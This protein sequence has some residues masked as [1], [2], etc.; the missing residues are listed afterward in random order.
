MWNIIIIILC[1]LKSNTNFII[2][3][4]PYIQ[5]RVFPQ[6]EAPYITMLGGYR[7]FQ[8]KILWIFVGKKVA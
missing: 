1:V 2:E 8:H 4:I 7:H 5:T 3:D 6:C